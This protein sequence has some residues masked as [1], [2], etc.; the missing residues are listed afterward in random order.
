LLTAL[1]VT[2]LLNSSSSA[3]SLEKVRFGY[4]SSGVSGVAI[5]LA[6]DAGLFQKHGLAVELI[7]VVGD[8]G[9]A[10][11]I[12]GELDYHA[13]LRM[14]LFAAA[15]G[16]PIKVTMVLRKAES[17]FI[18]AEPNIKNIQELKGK[19]LGVS[20]LGAASYPFALTVIRK[21]KLDP[22]HVQFLQTG[23]VANSVAALAAG[24]I[25]AA[26]VSIP[27]NIV[28]SQKGSH[29]LTSVADISDSPSSGLLGHQSTVRRNPRQLNKIIHALLDSLDFV[30]T[31]KAKVTAYMQQKWKLDSKLSDS[32]YQELLPGFSADGKIDPDVLKI[33]LAEAQQQMKNPHPIRATSI[34]DYTILNEVLSER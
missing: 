12:S 25:N 9:I 18:V 30:R 31:E 7:Q 21:A 22:Q 5:W 33:S 10:A 3:Q 20:R 24:Q 8:I 34:I 13:N 32:I 23:S 27:F 16:L 4:P 17:F 29:Q 14:G 28:L 2:L 15:R 1:A 19:K 26:V 11:L 6:K